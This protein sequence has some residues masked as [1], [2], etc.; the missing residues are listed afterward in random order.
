MSNDRRIIVI[1]GPSGS[2]K[3][4]L[5]HSLLK[6]Y[7]NFSFSVSHT[8]RSQRPG[9]KDGKDYHFIT[10]P[11]F[12]EMIDAG[13]FVEWAKVHGNY[14]GTSYGEVESK[15]NGDS[16]LLL[17]LDVQGAGNMKQEYPEALYVF[18]LPP[19]LRELEKRLVG[20]EKVKD[21][22][23]RMR[24]EIARE[25]IAQYSLYDYVVINDD[26]T[27]SYTVLESIII[28]F[29]NR[30]SNHRQFIDKMLRSE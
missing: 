16:Y 8:T 26:L 13:Q 7:H 29:Q 25:E 23:I 22:N 14:Y 3:S 15:S 27:R 11:G 28:A 18:V 21:E 30:V 19:D 17:D 6:K 20:R 1:S 2:G 9:E 12:R 10:A 24:L 4:T 5:I